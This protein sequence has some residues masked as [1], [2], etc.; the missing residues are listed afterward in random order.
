MGGADGGGNIRVG[1]IARWGG[2][3]AA[4]AWGTKVGVNIWGGGSSNSRNRSSHHTYK[5][6]KQ[7][8]LKQS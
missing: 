5:S 8:E 6:P 7:F 1:A 2:N 3:S 4:G